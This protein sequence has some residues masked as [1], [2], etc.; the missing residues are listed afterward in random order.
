[1]V[2]VFFFNLLKSVAKQFQEFDYRELQQAAMMEIYFDL[3]RTC[4]I[5]LQ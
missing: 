4:N 2:V 1:M 5:R 3:P